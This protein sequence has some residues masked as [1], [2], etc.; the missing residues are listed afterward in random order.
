MFQHS[1]GIASEHQRHGYVAEAVR[2][3]LRQAFAN[4]AVT[5]V[6]ATTYAWLEPSIGVL[7]ETGFM[8][9]ST[10]ARVGSFVSN[11]DVTPGK[12]ES[13]RRHERRGAAWVHLSLP[14][15]R[16]I[17]MWR[18]GVKHRLNP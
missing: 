17:D 13:N 18:C 7:R 14:V 9:V 2:A 6:V 5:V 11:A 4:S 1:R 10:N 12:G 15:M 3:P 8:D 16:T